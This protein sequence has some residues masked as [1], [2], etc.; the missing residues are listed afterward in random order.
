MPAGRFGSTIL[1]TA[2]WVAEVGAIVQPSLESDF[3]TPGSIDVE[4]HV[5]ARIL[6]HTL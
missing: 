1:D 5:E 3:L 2:L 4:S 6:L